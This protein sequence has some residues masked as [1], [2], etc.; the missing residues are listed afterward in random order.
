MLHDGIR[1]LNEAMPSQVAGRTYRA[2]GGGLSMGGDS[3]EGFN[4]LVTAASL[5]PSFEYGLEDLAMD[6]PYVQFTRMLP[7]KRAQRKRASRA[8]VLHS[9]NPLH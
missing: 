5:E 1:C 3:N 8:S 6:H 7:P 9:W 4:W 2:I